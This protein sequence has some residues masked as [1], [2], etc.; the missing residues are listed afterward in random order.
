MFGGE[1]CSYAVHDVYLNMLSSALLLELFRLLTA[2]PL[3]LYPGILLA[4]I[5]SFAAP[6]SKDPMKLKDILFMVFLVV[7]TLYPFVYY[8]CYQWSGELQQNGEF[9]YALLV[10]LIPFSIGVFVYWL[11]KKK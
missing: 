11:I 7:M 8:A 9:L 5:M 10:M 1:T 3:L 6:R 2:V 4:C